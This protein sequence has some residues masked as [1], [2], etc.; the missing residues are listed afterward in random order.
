MIHNFKE[1]QCFTESYVELFNNTKS[2][3]SHRKNVAI[4]PNA[5]VRSRKQ[6]PKYP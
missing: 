6:V 5:T 1:H 3:I 2:S 4:K